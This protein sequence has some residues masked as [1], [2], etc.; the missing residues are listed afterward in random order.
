SPRATPSVRTRHVAGAPDGWATSAHI[1]DPPRSNMTSV[2]RIPTTEP[3][4]GESPAIRRLSESAQQ[5][6]RSESPVL[7]EGDTGSGK[8]VLAAWLH[9]NGRRADCAFVDLNCAGFAR[10]LMDA[11]LFGHEKGAYTGAVSTKPGLLDIADGG[12][13]FLDEIGD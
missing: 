6:L 11:E 13:L 12:T 9:H 7:I 3:F 1:V 5:A 4:V 2:R 10:E 8:G